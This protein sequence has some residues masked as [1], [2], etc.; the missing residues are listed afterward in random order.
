MDRLSTVSWFCIGNVI[1]LIVLFA[2]VLFSSQKKHQE[3]TV[4]QKQ[5]NQPQVVQQAPAS[6][7][8]PGK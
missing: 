4:L 3:A 8:V 6:A 1:G 7:A 5:G 2:G